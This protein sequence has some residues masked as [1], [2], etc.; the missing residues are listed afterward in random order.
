MTRVGLARCRPGYAGI[1]APWGPGKTYPEIEG[2]L[3]DHAGDGPFNEVYAAVRDA[4]R[5][6]GLDANRFGTAE[7]NPIGDLVEPGK[8][9]V[10]KPNLI[11]H[12]NPED[13]S[14]HRGSLT[15]HGI[16]GDDSEHCSPS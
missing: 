2:L 10:L 11:R 1:A 5:G 13:E 7:W 3:S 9:I 16:S 15:Y 14:P 12:W 4:L 8:R 6:L